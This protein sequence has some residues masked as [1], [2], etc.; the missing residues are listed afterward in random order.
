M[1]NQASLTDYGLL[2]SLM[3]GND[4]TGERGD[5]ILQARSP[6]A[7]PGERTTRERLVTQIN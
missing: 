6:D 4:S 3:V 7:T 1:L 2:F 5:P